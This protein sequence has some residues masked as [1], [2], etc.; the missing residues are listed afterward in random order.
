MRTELLKSLTSG[1]EIITKHVVNTN[2]SPVCAGL[3]LL[4]RVSSTAQK[5]KLKLTKL[6]LLYLKIEVDVMQFDD[7]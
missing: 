2:K 6:K 1:T 5:I 3:E 4:N 7:L